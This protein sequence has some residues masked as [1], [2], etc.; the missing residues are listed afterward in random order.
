MPLE[1]ALPSPLYARV[2][3]LKARFD[4][5]DGKLEEMRPMLAGRQL[6]RRVFDAS[7]LA[8]QNEVQQE[9]LKCARSQRVRV[10]EDKLRIVGPVEVLSGMGATPLT[11]DAACVEA[12]VTGLDRG[13]ARAERRGPGEPWRRPIERGPQDR[14]GRE[15]AKRG[16]DGKSR[17][18]RHEVRALPRGPGPAEQNDAGDERA[19]APRPALRQLQ[20]LAPG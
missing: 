1:Q 18:V 6:L 20:A 14:Q 17:H 10:H 8:V 5:N 2:E 9:G 15:R 7:G 11:S 13:R 12:G 4:L 3:T 19:P 16:P